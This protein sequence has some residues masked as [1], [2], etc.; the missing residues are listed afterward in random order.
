LTRSQ[1]LLTRRR[2]WAFAAGL[3]VGAVAL[4]LL[5]V[6]PGPGATSRAAG[7]GGPEEPIPQ[8]DASVPA[9]NVMLFGSSPLESADETWGIGESNKA[10]GTPAWLIVRYTDAGWSLGAGMQDT[11]GQPLS[12]FAPVKSPLTADVTPDGSGALVGTGPQASKMLLVRN[13]GGPFQQTEPLPAPEE[14]EGALLKK[15]ETL[16]EEKRAP[17]LAALE[18]SPTSAGALVVPVNAEAGGVDDGVLHWNG[19]V[20]TREAIE[21]PEASKEEFRVLAIG[22]SSPTNA[23]LLAQLSSENYPA[24]SVALFRRHVG[25]GG[26]ATTWQPVAPKAGAAQHEAFPLQVPVSGGESLLKVLHEGGPPTVQTQLLTVTG[27]GVW[28]DGERAD[29]SVSSTIFFKPEAFQ[30]GEDWGRVTGSW[31]V[32]PSS[33]PACE[34]ELPEALPNGPSRSFAWADPGNSSCF[35]QRVITGLP[36]GVSLR[37]DGSSFTRVLSLGGGPPSNDVGGTFGAAFSGPREGWLGAEKLPVHLSTHRVA[38][39]LAPYPVSFRHSLVA[40]APQP[41]A[42]IGAPS[43]QALAVGDEGEVARFAPGEGWLPESLFTSGGRRAKPR[44]RA[45]A[46]PTP[47]RAYAVGDEGQMWLWRGETGLWEV[48]PATPFNFRGDLLGVAFDPNNPSRGYAVGQGGVLLSYGKTWTQEALPAGLAGANFTSIAFAGSEAIVAYRQ[49][50]D[51]S[52]NRYV[53]GL[54]INNGSGWQVDQQ[55]A[56]AMG[57]NVPWAVAG[58]QDGGAAFATGSAS[59]QGAGATVFERQ[60]ASAPWEPTTTPL[61]GFAEPGSLAL[62]REGGALRAIASGSVP[63]TYSVEHTPNPPP[64]LPP[65][66]VKP[67]PLN[68]GSGYLLRQTGEGWSDEEHE[69]N[70]VLQPPGSYNFFDTV[71]QPDPISAVLVD[72]SGAQGWAVGGFV[73]ATRSENDLDTAD[74]ER[75]PAD[76]VTPPGVGSAPITTNASHA[77]FAIG[78]NAQCAAPCAD[79]ENAGIGPDVWLSSAIARASQIS[80]VRAF[81][82]TGPRVTTGETAGPAT[83]QIPY[84]RELARYARLLESTSLPAYAAPSPTDLDPQS[85]CTFERLFPQFPFA[86]GGCAAGPQSAYYALESGSGTGRVRVI[87]LDDTRDVQPSQLSWLQGQLS[88]AGASSIPAIVIGNA[89]LGAQIAAGDGAAAEVAGA[90]VSGKAAAYFYDSPE[91]NVTGTLRAAGGTIPAFGSGTLGYVDS[92]AERSGAFLG[93]SGFLLVEVNTSPARGASGVEVK[94]IPNIG[95]LALE[96]QDGT[97]LHRS[98]VASF[99]GLARR[100]RAGNRSQN[101]P[102][103]PDTDPYIPIPSNCVG[104]PCA[105]RLAPEYS[106]S[107]SNPR[108]GDFV[109]PNLASGEANAVLLD[110]AGK[111]IPDPQSGLFCAYNAGTTTV[112]ISAGGLSSSLPVTVQA[113]SVRRPCG[114]VPLNE[115]PSAQQAASVP[116][117]APAQAPPA[118]APVSQSPP[119]VVPVP[120]PPA[121]AATPAPAPAAHAAAPAP[122][123]VPAALPTALPAFV[124]LPVPSPARPTPPSGTSA[125]TSPVEAPE[126]EE[127]EEEA[128]ES[129]GNNAAAYSP[130]EHEPSP[131]YLVGFLVLAAFAGASIRRR[132][133]RG[134]RDVRVAPATI[135]AMRAERAMQR[136]ES[137]R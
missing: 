29:A 99:A 54:L 97:L 41:G 59:G 103:A 44:L 11:A 3:V 123:F 109:A 94:L 134:S 101:Q 38:S 80:G 1:R 98:Q 23:W 19:H 48:D 96:A 8:A 118:N 10:G 125:V 58:L 62:F 121:P 57:G 31:C 51:P 74:V 55:A 112:T 130:H 85:E 66:F 70:D 39:K 22:A 88:E 129:V 33:G 122:F 113:G 71:Y 89:D 6:L 77:I 68:A 30:P 91:R 136:R 43:S 79:L 120:P 86:G 127:E 35:G 13:P 61:P 34:R 20:W 72:P 135:T 90:L 73:A 21:V 60:N 102:I 110:G 53:G 64:G 117:P 17:L 126:R 83:L 119:P 124:P 82:Y 69:G 42:P 132:P 16:F 114:T 63:D 92:T 128:T 49:L 95:E 131:L 133:R 14:G 115:T 36:D 111:T 100:P 107:S 45:V 78:G 76:H 27:E 7:Q 87:V 25:E 50:P 2:R 116:P 137:R 15:G 40:I 32:P 18:E 37:L 104:T 28:V 93:A 106:F 65:T 56:A 46:W 67:Y 75:Y 81:L 5:G 108:V 24:G 26:E 4:T 84:E 105:S 47:T 12:G 9:Q 52:E